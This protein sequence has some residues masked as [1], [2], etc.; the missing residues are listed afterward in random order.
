MFAARLTDGGAC[1]SYRHCSCKKFPHPPSDSAL[2]CLVYYVRGEAADSD[3][4]AGETSTISVTGMAAMSFS[5]SFLPTDRSA[6]LP[7]VA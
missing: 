1:G 2:P 7:T 6:R 4:P 5:F 3:Q